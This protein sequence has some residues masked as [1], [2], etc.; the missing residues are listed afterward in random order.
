MRW[1][2]KWG[3]DTTDA[4]PLITMIQDN[5]VTSRLRQEGYN[6]INLPSGYEYTEGIQADVQLKPWMY[7]D[8]FSQTL[9]VELDLVP[10]HSHRAVQFAPREYQL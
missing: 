3:E 6:I 5:R 2:R 1:L 9:A 8:N 7:L 10:V 4:H